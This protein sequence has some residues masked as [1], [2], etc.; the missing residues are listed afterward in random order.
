V[1]QQFG[2]N[3]T[4]TS[5]L[6]TIAFGFRPNFIRIDASTAG[7]AYLNF[8]TAAASTGST[9][10]SF[11]L[12]SGNSAPIVLSNPVANGM[13]SALTAIAAASSTAVIRV[14]ALRI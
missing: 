9:G 10:G 5:D 3:V 1:A 4:L 14:I 8:S 7:T 11:Q 12:T 6:S 2:Q 13:S